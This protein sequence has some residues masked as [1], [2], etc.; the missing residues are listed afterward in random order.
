MVVEQPLERNGID[1][2]G[3]F[4]RSTGEN[5]Y[6][7]VAVDYFTKCA[8]T[9]SI[10]SCTAV[11]V[12]DF[13]IHQIVLRHGT[14]SNVTSDRGTCFTSELM[15]EVLRALETNHRTTTTY[16]PQSKG[17]VER[18]NHTLVDMLAMYVSSDHRNW[19]VIPPYVTFAYNSSV[20]ESTATT[21]FSLLYGR[22]PLLPI[23]VII[24]STPNLHLDEHS[25][26]RSRRDEI[27]AQL[28]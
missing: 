4:P 26:A 5:K 10:P 15:Q 7:E 2:L 11:E 14:P 21:P 24:G 16:H 17:L 19:D 6:S 28:R 8:N 22:E 12:G 3:P 23:D 27:F 13:F 20:Q 9:K 1:I 25:P 18:L